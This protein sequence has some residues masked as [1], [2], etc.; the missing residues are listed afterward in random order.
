MPTLKIKLKYVIAYLLLF[1][2][3]PLSTSSGTLGIQE[4]LVEKHCSTV[5]KKKTH[6]VARFFI[7]YFYIYVAIFICNLTIVEFVF[8]FISVISLWEIMTDICKFE[9]TSSYFIHYNIDIFV[10][11]YLPITHTFNNLLSIY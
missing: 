3:E 5:K 2:V 11:I 7:E 4:T 9:N 10:T 1:L 8:V 6:I